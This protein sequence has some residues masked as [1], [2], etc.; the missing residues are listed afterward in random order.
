MKMNKLKA[1]NYKTLQSLIA[2][3]QALLID[4]RREEEWIQ[5]GIIKGALLLSFDSQNKDAFLKDFNKIIKDKNQ[6]II[7]YCA[8]A[9]R[10]KYAGNL[11]IEDGYLD[12]FELEGGINYGWLNLGQKSISPQI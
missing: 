12:V 7:L 3:N 1:L 5:S 4:I 11:L 10:T 9:N 8:R 6:K 2:N